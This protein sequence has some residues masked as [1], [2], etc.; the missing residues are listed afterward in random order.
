MHQWGRGALPDPTLELRDINGVLV[1]SNDNWMDEPIPATFRDQ[2]PP[3]DDLGVSIL[4]SLPA[5]AY[6]AIVVGK[7]GVTGVGLVEVYSLP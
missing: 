7:D 4:V 2:S 3:T 5:G 6:T 1:V